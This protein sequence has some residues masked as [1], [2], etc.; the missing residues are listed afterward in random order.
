MTPVDEAQK[1]QFLR[2]I[3]P[4]AS[5]VCPQYGID[6][7][8]CIQSAAEASSYGRFALGYNWWGLQG[9]GDAGYYTCIVPVRTYA[10]AGGGWES[11][12]Q[13]VAKFRSPVSAVTAWCRASKGAVTCS[14]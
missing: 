3:S 6:P 7:Q 5:S 4:A 12:E 9:A 14:V 2:D 10:L 1:E 11:R 13:Q 8:A